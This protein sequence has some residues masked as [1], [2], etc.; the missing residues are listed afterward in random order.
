MTQDSHSSHPLIPD[1]PLATFDVRSAEGSDAVALAALLQQLG[2]DEPPLD[3]LRLARCLEQPGT[4][5]LTLV[6]ERDGTLLGTCS[7]HLIE[8]IA[9]NFARSAVLEDMVVDSRARGQG[10]GQA[11]IRRAVEQAREWGCYK[12]ALSS[13]LQ[14]EA[15]H[16][17]YAAMGFSAHGVSLSLSLD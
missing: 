8:H 9:H 16:R 5:T 14:R 2:N 15:A 13:H 1:S 6:A 17:F 7:L 11:L 4:Q 10:V 12:L 3:T